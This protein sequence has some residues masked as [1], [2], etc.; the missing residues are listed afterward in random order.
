MRETDV[1]TRNKGEIKG[2]AGVC[3][4]WG[5]WSGECKASEENVREGGGG[6]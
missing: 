2:G 6:C 1:M 4:C 3:V 5:S